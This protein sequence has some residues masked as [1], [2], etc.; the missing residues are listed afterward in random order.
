MLALKL[1]WPNPKGS[2][3]ILLLWTPIV[4]VQAFLPVIIIVK[5]RTYNLIV[6][7]VRQSA[8]KNN[9]VYITLA[10]QTAERFV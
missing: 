10:N 2:L 4:V 3:I 1:P 6:L 5:A 9:N 7:C 8:M